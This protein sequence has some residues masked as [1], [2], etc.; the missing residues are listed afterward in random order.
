MEM[1]NND[2]VLC[3]EKMAELGEDGDGN[4]GNDGVWRNRLCI[5]TYFSFLV[6]EIEMRKRSK[7]HKFLGF[8][9]FVGVIW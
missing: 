1:G 9:L 7:I 3:S 2:G 5:H 6:R 8:Y 4:L